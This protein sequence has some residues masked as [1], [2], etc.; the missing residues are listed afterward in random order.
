MKQ[1]VVIEV[2]MKDQK[3]R[4]KALKTIVGQSGVESTALQGQEKNQIEVIG[5]GIDAVV[6][7]TLLRKNVG[8]AVLLSVSPIGD[9][10]EGDAK[11]GEKEPQVITWYAHPHIYS[12]GVPNYHFCQVGDSYSDAPLLHHHVIFEPYSSGES[13]KVQAKEGWRFARSSNGDRGSGVRCLRNY[14]L[15]NPMGTRL[16]REAIAGAKR[17]EQ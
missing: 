9:K 8:R 16:E 13:S 7:T 15:T 5:D 11:D 4:I 14:L 17:G 3:S 1:K 12:G 10:K 6:L 2:Y